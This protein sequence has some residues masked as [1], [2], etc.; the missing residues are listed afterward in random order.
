[1]QHKLALLVVVFLST[2]AI[3]AIAAPVELWSRAIRSNY[4]QYSDPDAITA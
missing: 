4:Q 1:M 2:V 3:S